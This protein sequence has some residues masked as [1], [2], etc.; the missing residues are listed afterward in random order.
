[1][2]VEL[3]AYNSIDLGPVVPVNE[4]PKRVISYE[5]I[6]FRSKRKPTDLFTNTVYQII[7][8]TLTVKVLFP[9]A[10]CQQYPSQVSVQIR[11]VQL[12]RLYP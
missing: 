11:T 4:R 2:L 9:I 8:M 1:M 10:L 3:L 5:E 12:A 6:G 7:W